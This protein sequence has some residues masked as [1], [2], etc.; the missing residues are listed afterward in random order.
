MNALQ[1]VRNQIKAALSTGCEVAQKMLGNVKLGGKGVN[2]AKLTQAYSKYLYALKQAKLNGLTNIGYLASVISIH[3]CVNGLAKKIGSLRRK[4]A[5]DFHKSI[6]AHTT[7]NAGCFK[8]ILMAT[9]NVKSTIK[10]AG[11]TQLS[12]GKLSSSQ[13]VAFVIS[14]YGY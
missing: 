1:T 2:T 6:E 3:T 14:G 7:K 10:K 4:T 8:D 9:R 13:A 12:L 5:R 11:K